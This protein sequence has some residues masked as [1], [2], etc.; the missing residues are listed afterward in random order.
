MKTVVV[1]LYPPQAPFF[2][3]LEICLSP[4]QAI[5]WHF[6]GVCKEETVHF[7]YY[8]GNINADAI[9]FSSGFDP[10]GAVVR[11]YLP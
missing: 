8:P 10:K 11:G 3:D 7:L 4:P 1:I 9:L 2:R 5:F 6:F